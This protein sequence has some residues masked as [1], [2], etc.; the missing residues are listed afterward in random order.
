MANA[1]ALVESG[2]AIIVDGGNGEVQI[3]PG[4]EIEAAYAE[5]A[6]LRARRQEQYRALRDV[7]AVTR[8]GVAVGLQLNAGLIVDL[9]HLNETGAEG[10]GLFRTELQFMVAERMPSAAE[11]QVLYE[12][13]FDAV[14]DLPVTI[15]TL[16]NR[17]RQGAAL[18]EVA[19]EG[20]P[21]SWAGGRSASAST[22]RASCGCSCVRSSRPPAGRPLKIMFPMVATVEEFVPGAGNRRAREGDLTGTAPAAADCRLGVMVEVPS[23][24]SRWDEIAAEA[25]FLSVGSN[26]LMQFLFAVDRENARS[27]TASIR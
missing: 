11:Q 5:K 22:G 12:A 8:D 23:L 4:P 2:D 6:R 18:H 13:V 26:D 20:E 1:T 7:P 19:R 21:G 16:D 10:V 17:R 27:P 14:G 25:D 3:R 9:S 15:R 24:L